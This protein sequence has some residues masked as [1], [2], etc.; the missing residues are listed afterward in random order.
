MRFQGPSPVK[1]LLG[2]V[3]GVRHFRRIVALWQWDIVVV[4][5]LPT[6]IVALD[7]WS[8]GFLTSVLPELNMGLVD[9][10]VCVE[11]GPEFG[12]LTII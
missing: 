6:I 11:V 9:S 1:T 7:G 12:G 3:L 10:S 8:T 4:S 5:G 2:R